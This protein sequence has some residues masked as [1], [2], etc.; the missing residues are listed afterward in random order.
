M[1]HRQGVWQKL[2]QESDDAGRAAK[3]EKCASDKA[4]AKKAA[5]AGSRTATERLKMFHRQADAQ[6]MGKEIDEAGVATKSENCTTDNGLC[7]KQVARRRV[8]ESSGEV[9]N[10]PLTRGLAEH[11]QERAR[12][13]CGEQKRKN[14]PLTKGIT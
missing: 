3:L 14:A 8:K 9:K 7:K 4:L 6:K 2:E 11:F 12:G 5:Q 10:P 1:F 13:E